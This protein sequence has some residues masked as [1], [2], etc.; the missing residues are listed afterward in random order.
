MASTISFEALTAELMALSPKDQGKLFSAVLLSN[1]GKAKVTKA[2]KR[3]EKLEKDPDAPTRPM[4]AYMFFSNKIVWPVLKAHAETLDEDEAKILRSASARTQIPAALWAT[5]KVLDASARKAAMAAITEKSI[6]AAY[7][8]WKKDPPAPHCK[9]DKEAKSGSV[10]SGG[11]KRA[12]GAKK[13]T[14]LP[15]AEADAQRAAAASAAK[16]VTGSE[17]AFAA[18][19]AAL[20]DSDEEEEEASPAAGGAATPSAVEEVEV[21]EEDEEE[22]EEDEE[23]VI[24]LKE[25]SAPKKLLFGKQEIKLGEVFLS[26]DVDGRTYI[27]E[28]ASRKYMGLFMSNIGRIDP[29][30]ENPLA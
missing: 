28:K 10:A 6:L 8:V 15:A 23:E 13:S 21:E 24:E 25:W 29:R 26:A 1:A 11:S 27:Y 17:K 7:A 20:S 9:A 2:A 3:A 4:G 14:P 16:A 18:A 5:I 30:K 12:K 22:A 19:A